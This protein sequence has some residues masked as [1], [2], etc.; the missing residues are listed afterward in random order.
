MVKVDDII[1]ITDSAYEK[2][3]IKLEG[4]RY[5]VRKVKKDGGVNAAPIVPENSLYKQEASGVNWDTLGLSDKGRPRS[6]PKNVYSIIGTMQGDKDGKAINNTA[7]L[8]T[9]ATT[10]PTS[11]TQDDDDEEPSEVP[12]DED[13]EIE[14]IEI[15]ADVV[16]P[17]AKKEPSKT[18]YSGKVATSM[19]KSGLC[20]NTDLLIPFEQAREID[21]DKIPIV[22]GTTRGLVLDK[23][24]GADFR[25]RVCFSAPVNFLNPMAYKSQ[26]DLD[27][28]LEKN[29]TKEFMVL[30]Q[31]QIG[32]K[33]ADVLGSKAKDTESIQWHT[34][35]Q[36]FN[37]EAEVVSIRMDWE[38]TSS[39]DAPPT[40][41]V[42]GLVDSEG[43]SFSLE[44]I[45][46][47]VDFVGSQSAAGTT[48]SASPFGAS[49]T[50]NTGAKGLPTSDTQSSSPF[51][52][53]IAT[54]GD[55]SPAATPDKKTSIKPEQLP[56]NRFPSTQK[57]DAPALYA[58]RSILAMSYDQDFD[59][60]APFEKE[61]VVDWDKQPSLTSKD[62]GYV[63]IVLEVKDGQGYV[64]N[65]FPGK[66]E[67]SDMLKKQP[68]MWPQYP[69][70]V[71]LILPQAD[72]QYLYCPVD[73]ITPDKE[74]GVSA[75][76]NETLDFSNPNRE[77]WI[78]EVQEVKYYEAKG[79]IKDIQ[80][81]QSYTKTTIAGIGQKETSEETLVKTLKVGE[82][83][84]FGVKEPASST[85]APLKGKLAKVEVMKD[86]S[87]ENIFL[88]AESERRSLR[89]IEDYE[90]F[91]ATEKD[92]KNNP[93]F[94]IV[95]ANE[96][97]KENSGQIIRIDLSKSKEEERSD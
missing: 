75:L 12:S 47:T 87:R 54:G 11:T 52:S 49:M 34:N 45:V 69:R 17:E 16:E 71:I 78:D 66:W 94:L 63:Q 22:G 31:Y 9:S 5:W 28:S 48:T 74:T 90:V 13:E 41:I 19:S 27:A 42:V 88:A 65:R 89:V 59:A 6:L 29:T 1:E 73:E 36:P 10:T 81:L 53:G 30:R 7:T 33:V 84:E 15:V 43:E 35:N 56:V 46:Q 76:G 83:Y 79:I 32:K 68:D 85:I 8:T 26:K 62:T 91:F 58:L 25:V 93:Q 51:G 95:L 77:H 24:N 61:Y 18:R 40:K 14:E 64:T 38:D 82:T 50:T 80:L 55:A 2:N 60:F 57:G 3:G 23:K 44:H 67:N 37:M 39:W 21:V 96:K 4:R 72:S 70:R 20:F 97:G 86:G 92:D